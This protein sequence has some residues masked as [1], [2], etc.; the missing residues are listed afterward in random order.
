MHP[1]A[2][3]MIDAA[4]RLVAEQG[5]AALTVQAVQREANQRNKSA[6]Q[7]HFGGRQGLVTAVLADRMVGTEMRR[8]SMLLD[9]PEGASTR[10]LVEVLVLPVIESVLEHDHSY[11]ARFLIQTLSDPALGLA[12]LE[13][14]DTRALD[15]TQ[16]RLRQRLPNLPE[17]LRALRVQ[18]TLG[19]AVLVLA[20]YE[21]GALPQLGKDELTTEIVDTCHGLL[22]APST[23]P[24]NGS[25]LPEPVGTVSVR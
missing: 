21:A 5:L 16:A 17:S 19:H 7:Y 22:G 8:T 6:V 12:A 24:A 20:A 13:A 15:A 10:R 23:L 25:R 14:V 11:W 4:E 2:R 18:S 9:L 3:S 1:A